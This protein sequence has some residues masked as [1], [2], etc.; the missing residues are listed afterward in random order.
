[1]WKGEV[2]W[3]PTWRATQNV[4]SKEPECGQQKNIRVHAW[5]VE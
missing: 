5:K 1:M 2:S 3:L 4:E